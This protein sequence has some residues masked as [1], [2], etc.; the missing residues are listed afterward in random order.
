MGKS[1]HRSPE[2]RIF[3]VFLGLLATLCGYF[4]QILESHFTRQLQM[5]RYIHLQASPTL[6]LWGSQ[7][8]LSSHQTVGMCWTSLFEIF[9]P[10]GLCCYKKT[11]TEK[12]I[13]SMKKAAFLTLVTSVQSL[14]RFPTWYRKFRKIARFHSNCDF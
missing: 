3:P 4:L 8:L 5:I 10:L 1:F 9:R 2:G 6:M 12:G 11:K 13:H 14:S 7:E